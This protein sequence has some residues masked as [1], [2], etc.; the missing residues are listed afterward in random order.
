MPSTLAEHARRAGAQTKEIRAAAIGVRA[1][2][3][4]ISDWLA[5]VRLLLRWCPS[6]NK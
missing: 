3:H 1:R 2:R 6:S 5:T 4:E